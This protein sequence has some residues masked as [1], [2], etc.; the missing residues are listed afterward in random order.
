MSISKLLAAL[1]RWAIAEPPL[2][3][4]SEWMATR[5]AKHAEYTERQLDQGRVVHDAAW[6]KRLEFWKGVEVKRTP[7]QNV[8][9]FKRRA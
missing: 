6:F 4:S 1:W 2:R 8:A 3:M 9:P 7:K 5:L